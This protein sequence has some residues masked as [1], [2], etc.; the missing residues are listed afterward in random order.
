MLRENLSGETYDELVDPRSLSNFLAANQWAK[1]EE[2]LNL[3]EVWRAPDEL[4][5]KPRTVVVPLDR[6]LEDFSLRMGETVSALLGAY[7]LRPRTLVDRIVSLRADV[8]YVRIDQESTD[9]T[10]PLKQAQRTLESIATMVRA[11]ATTVVSPG[12]TH[13]GR[14]PALVEDFVSD[15]LRLGHT[16]RGSFI[17]TVAARHDFNVDSQRAQSLGR[18]VENVHESDQATDIISDERPPFDR[19]EIGVER[20]RDAIVPLARRVM[21]TLSNGLSGAQKLADI[22]SDRSQFADDTEWPTDAESSGL[23]LELAD[24]LQR[25]TDES[26]LRSLSI[27]FDW[28]ESIDPPP[29]VRDQIVF[30]RQHIEALPRVADRLRR[31]EE[32]QN[33]DLIGPV[34]ALSRRLKDLKSPIGDVTILA[35]VDDVPRKVVAELTGADYDLA[36]QAYRNN[37]P[38]AISGILVK[39]RSWQLEGTVRLDREM[40]TELLGMSSRRRGRELE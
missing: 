27:D 13:K 24:A 18:E 39:R 33:V 34:I 5:L 7:Q 32:D 4:H 28:A 20:E 38:I 19:P 14:R 6:E 29:N 2:N 36:I 1:L 15:D 10:I 35:Q 30:N 12:H 25:L 22:S 31:L 40:V 23:S 16:K 8:F 3:W 37:L 26:G 11:A 17:V 21:V 9:G